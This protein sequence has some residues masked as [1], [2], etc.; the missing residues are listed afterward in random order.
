MSGLVTRTSQYRSL[1]GPP[2][3]VVTDGVVAS[4]LSTTTVEVTEPAA[5]VTV[6][7]ISPSSVVEGGSV[8][9][10]ISGSGF[11]PGASVSL[12]G[13]QGPAPVVSIVA[14]NSTTIDANIT[15]RSGGPPRDRF[16][17]VRVTN[18]DAG[19]GVL[20]GGFTVTPN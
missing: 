12:E 18:P 2:D 20:E 6:D 7:S 14:V 19:S 3:L 17:D 16:W 10:T 1:G 9:V 15:T 11:Q 4:E 8:T 5:G 13:G